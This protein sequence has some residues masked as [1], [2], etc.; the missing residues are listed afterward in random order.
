MSL[1]RTLAALERRVPPTMLG[2][3][4]A[5]RRSM[6]ALGVA[7]TIVV[8]CVPLSAFIYIITGP[9]ERLLG[10]VNTLATA[11]LA[12]VTGVESSAGFRP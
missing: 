4:D 3:F 11:I 7:A 9:G 8:L 10:A 1:H 12:G 5:Y 6:A 2:D